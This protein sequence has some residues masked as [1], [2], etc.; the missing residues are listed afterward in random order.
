MKVMRDITILNRKNVAVAVGLALSAITG[1][2]PAAA[3]A[4]PAVKNSYQSTDRGGVIY[5][6]SNDD[7]AN[8]IE[9][10][11]R[12]P[13]GQIREV[14]RA[15]VSTGGM[16]AASNAAIDPLGSQGSLVFSEEHDMLFGVNAGD[17]TV[18][19]FK[20]RDMPN[21]IVRRHLRPV[22]TAVVPSGGDLPVSVA[23]SG[24]KLYVLNAGGEGMV[25]TF[26]ITV[27]GG[28]NM[29]TSV[30]LGLSNATEVPFDNV[31]A[32]GQV[33]VDSLSRKLLVTNAS[34]QE[35][36][37]FT[38]DSDGLPDG[39]LTSTPTSGVVPFS[40]DT[41]PFGNILV[42]EAGSGAVSAFDSPVGYP[43]VETTA[44]VTNGQA[45]T[46]WIVATDDGYAYVTNTLSDTIS[47]Y[48]YQRNGELALVDAT[49]ATVSVGGAPIDMTLAGAGNF[50]L[51]LDAGTGEIS[52]FRVDHTTGALERVDVEAGLPAGAGIQGIAAND[53]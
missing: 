53:F 3:H 51:T 27:S 40:F 14:P 5:V 7:T 31:M 32:P 4:A 19:A 45:A 39:E 49:A 38:L 25:T 29:L 42:T 10:Y 37:S 2:M 15:S 47:L 1:G 28:L 20:T 23:V 22:R 41:T 8:T 9:V 43:L 30:S 44:S 16:G 24:D 50:L 36:L 48:S 35:L 52:S 46:C 21:R 34:G 6:M 26:E 11:L 12:R 33:G 17:N 18:F 13:N